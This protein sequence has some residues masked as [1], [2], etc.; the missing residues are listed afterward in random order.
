MFQDVENN[1]IQIFNAIERALSDEYTVY[2]TNYDPC[3]LSA[4]FREDFN[5]EE[6]NR[7]ES[8]EVKSVNFRASTKMKK[9]IGVSGFEKS[10]T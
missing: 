6:P 1:I 5:P 9:R 8:I 2:I 10:E 4:Q 7:A 3:E